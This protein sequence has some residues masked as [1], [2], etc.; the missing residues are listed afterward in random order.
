[1]NGVARRERRSTDRRDRGLHVGPAL[2]W[3]LLEHP[4][5]GGREVGRDIRPDVGDRGRRLVEVGVHDRHDRDGGEREPAG[6]HLVRDDA[7]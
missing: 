1:M 6:Q 5:H 4:H 7:E 3:L 2:L